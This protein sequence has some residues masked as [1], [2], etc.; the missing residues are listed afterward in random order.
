[1][2]MSKIEQY[3]KTLYEK[4]NLPISDIYLYLLNDLLFPA[5][6]NFYKRFSD[7]HKLKYIIL[8]KCYFIN[9]KLRNQAPEIIPTIFNE[10][11][12]EYLLPI[13]LENKEN[14]WILSAW[15]D[16]IIDSSLKAK[17][18]YLDNK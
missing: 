6:I 11:I 1:M 4:F 2:D 10:L 8:E 16:I 15:N 12:C 14:D 13:I 3:E 5:L 17:N 9:I 7:D 18:Y